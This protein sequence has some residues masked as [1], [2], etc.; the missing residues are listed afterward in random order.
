VF[1]VRFTGGSLPDSVVVLARSYH[2][3]GSLV[4]PDSVRFV[5]VYVP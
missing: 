2:V 3:D 4:A 5:V 1:Q